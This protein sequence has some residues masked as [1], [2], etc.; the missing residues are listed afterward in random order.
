MKITSTAF[1][2]NQLMPS[3]YTCDGDD[4]NPQLSI[5]GV[6]LD[7]KSLILIMDDPDAIKPAGMVWDHWLVFNIPFATIEIPEGQ[8]PKGV[9]GLG[10]SGNLDYHGPCPPDTEHRYFF[11]LYALD[12][13]LDLKEGVSKSEIEEAMRG[14][15]IEQAELIGLYNKIN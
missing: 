8:E 3:K 11:K 4:I 2:H 13:M 5:S 6:P 1:Q 7:T 15:I 10:T 9:H 12:V 14:H